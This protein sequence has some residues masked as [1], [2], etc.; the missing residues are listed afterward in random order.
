MSSSHPASNHRRQSE[1]PS[2]A[3]SSSNIPFPS[4][5]RKVSLDYMNGQRRYSMNHGTLPPADNQLHP[6]NQLPSGMGM[7]DMYIPGYPPSMMSEP[8]SPYNT[9]MPLHSNGLPMNYGQLTMGLS[10]APPPA[11]HPLHHNN[12]NMED[13]RYHP[14]MMDYLMQQGGHLYSRTMS[15]DPTRFPPIPTPNMHNGRNSLLVSRSMSSPLPTASS[16]FSSR[17]ISTP[18][19]NH[20]PPVHLMLPKVDGKRSGESS[21]M[22]SISE[23]VKP[24]PPTK[25]IK[26]RAAPSSSFPIKL[27]KI[28]SNPDCNEYIDW[29]PHGR[30]FRILK[31]KGFEEHVLPKFFRSSRYSSFMRQV[32]L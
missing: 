19:P 30:A 22:T 26:K 32:R 28:L 23:E 20:S 13:R 21:S 27:H 9:G 29:L 8:P 1:R 16:S 7:S 10:P 4:D 31:A 15:M 3:R 18:G 14:G 17:R 24:Q 6:S 5:N 12:G 25:K 11:P 2:M